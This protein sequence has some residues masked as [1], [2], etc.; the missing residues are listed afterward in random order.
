MA[1]P[2]DA[3]AGR[4]RGVAQAYDVATEDAAGAKI[5][6]DGLHAGVDADVDAGVDAGVGAGADV[7]IVQL[8]ADVLIEWATQLGEGLMATGVILGVVEL[9]HL[10]AEIRANASDPTSLALLS[11]AAGVIL[12]TMVRLVLSGTSAK[13]QA[14]AASVPIQALAHFSHI[15]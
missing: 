3:L 4:R 6:S 10:G 15:F 9:E 13:R 8:G 11:L 2:A 1:R 7:D 14:T 5:S 12:L